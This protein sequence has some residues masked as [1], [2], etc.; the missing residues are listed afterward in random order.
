M[1]VLLFLVIRFYVVEYFH[2]ELSG[3]Y[4]LYI[5]FSGLRNLI[6]V[7]CRHWFRFVRWNSPCVISVFAEMCLAN[8]EFSK[9]NMA[10]SKLSVFLSIGFL[11]V[12][13]YVCK[14]NR[15][16]VMSLRIILPKVAKKYVLRFHDRN[17]EQ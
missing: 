16:H 6:R 8:N 17:F 14:H 13:M 1:R 3:I 5:F 12:N 4:D 2:S 9:Q 10:A 7:S 15:L 11:M